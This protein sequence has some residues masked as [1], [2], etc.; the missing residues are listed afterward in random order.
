MK[1]HHVG[2]GAAGMQLFV[3]G[4]TPRH[5]SLVSDLGRRSVV[6]AGATEEQAAEAQRRLGWARRSALPRALAYEC[7]A[8]V[9]FE[10]TAVVGASSEPIVATAA[11]RGVCLGAAHATPVSLGPT[12]PS[13]RARW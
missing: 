9:A 10:Q 1:V 4:G 13:R 5:P 3:L 11:G 8:V 7:C 2:T 12:A 6:V